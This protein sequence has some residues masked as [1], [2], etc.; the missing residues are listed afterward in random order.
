[1]LNDGKYEYRYDD[2]G[3]LTQKKELLT[4][5]LTTYEWD[6]RNRL[7]KVVSGS[8]TVEYGYD[9]EDKRVGTKLNGV[10]TEKYV[11]DGADIALVIDGAGTIVERYL[12]GDG[13]DN[14]LSRCQLSTV[15]CQLTWSLGDRQGSVVDL[16][17]EN[18][19][20]LNHFVYDGFG[21][22]TGTTAVDFRYGYTGRELDTETGLYYY[23]ARYY[24]SK[25]GRFISEDPIGFGAGDTNLYRYVG[26]NS[27]NYTDPTG[28]LA[29]V[30]GG[31]IFGGIFGG[32][33]AL[34][35]DLETGNFGWNTIGNVATG[36]AVG[37][38]AGAIV[39]SGVGLVAGLATNALAAGFT[40]VLGAEA[41]AGT[42]TA[43][44][45]V[46]TTIAAGFT[47]Y[48]AY[49]AGGN[50]GR[51]KY[52]TGALD[53]VGVGIGASKV[54]TGVTKGIPNAYT[55]DLATAIDN[56]PM[57]G[58][59]SQLNSAGDKGGQIVSTTRSLAPATTPPGWKNYPSNTIATAP[60]SENGIPSE[61]VLSREDL[62][63][64]LQL[65]HD[66]LPEQGSV[67]IFRKKDVSMGKLRHIGRITGDE[68]SVFTRG[69]QRI[70]IRGIGDQVKVSDNLLDDILAGK[71]G[72]YSGHTHPPGTGIEPGPGD[73]PWLT[74]LGVNRSAI[75]GMDQEGNKHQNLYGQLPQHDLEIY[76]EL[77][78]Q[79]WI[80]KFYGQTE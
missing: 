47:A 14:V 43:A 73:R 67:A 21:N 46:N 59:P 50:F 10:T 30:A 68:Y 54:F 74:R 39:A 27:T 25:V 61:L 64:T 2:E 60:L 49:N 36:A 32:L 29:Q 12:Y 77:S 20:V 18:G 78:R 76:T 7:M 23:R 69:S 3:N 16:V 44:A 52:W 75:W 24:D 41:I 28:E 38:V 45:I 34:A 4:G 62:Q 8:Q 13:V 65:I 63:P 15:N 19:T 31:A 42:A 56:L 33:Y 22:R 72:R 70:V 57:P 40:A 55:A 26:N 17:S 6:Y 79:K 80:R 11:Y 9:A 51:K 48:G 58:N 5:N 1:V 66:R 71:L 37:A 53:L 35:N